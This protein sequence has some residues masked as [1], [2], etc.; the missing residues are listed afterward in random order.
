MRI[1]ALNKLFTKGQIFAK[2]RQCR[3]LK[4]WRISR[5]IITVQAL[6]FGH[7]QMGKI[8]VHAD[9]VKRRRGDSGETKNQQQCGNAN[10]Q[11]RKS[12][13]N[14]TSCWGTRRQKMLRN[15]TPCLMLDCN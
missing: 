3:E 13:H 7:L 2:W 12:M 1:S 14:K 8:L 11:S 5:L 9:A 15:I 4:Y 10:T 6:R